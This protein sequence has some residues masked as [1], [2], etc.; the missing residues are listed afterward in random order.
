[1]NMLIHNPLKQL[2]SLIKRLPK[3]FYNSVAGLR[4]ARIS[5]EAFRL[6]IFLTIPIIILALAL[7][8]TSIEKALLIGSWVLVLIIELLN[9]ALELAVDRI[10]LEIHPL[11]KK[12]KD[13]ASAAVLLTIINM[14]AVW[15]IIIFS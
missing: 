1:M 4:S 5:E 12:I 11:S 3:A 15:S 14:L 2:T 7:G 6:E 10:S 8:V 9:S 13:M